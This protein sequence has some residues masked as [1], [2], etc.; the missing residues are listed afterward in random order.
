MEGIKV[1]FNNDKNKV[2]KGESWVYT[3][4][5]NIA[6]VLNYDHSEVM[7]RI[8]KIL[9]DYKIEDS[10][11]KSESSN[12]STNTEYIKR[13]TD[14]T[15]SLAFY[16]NSQNKLQPFYRLSKDLLIILIFSFRKLEKAQE[17]Q[18][19]YIA[20]FNEMEKEL[21]W[22][23]AR[24][25]GIDV[26]N[27][28]TDSIKQYLDSPDYRAYSNFTDLVYRSLF[29]KN[30]KNIRKENGLKER[31]NVREFLDSDSLDL[32]KSLEN[33]IGVLLSYGLKYRSIKEMI[34]SKYINKHEV[35][36]INT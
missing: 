16:K 26:R 27:N 30:T 18:L 7:K 12:V 31:A 14:F 29:N 23:K 28:L 9:T 15:Y 1:I 35:K 21:H 10:E 11:L 3:D 32:V 17:L 20:K 34:Q 2:L 24:Y 8:R 4:T 5:L 6:E 25:L 33:E 13:H 19:A 36:L 22:W